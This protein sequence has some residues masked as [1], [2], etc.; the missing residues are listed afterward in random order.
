MLELKSLKF[1]YNSLPFI[2]DIS[3]RLKPGEILGL[4]GPNGSGK[5][6]ILKCLNRILKPREGEIFLDN[7]NINRLSLRETAAILGYVPQSTHSSFALNVFEMVLLGR[8]P[9]VNWKVSEKDRDIAFGMLRTMGLENMSF[10]IF[11]ELSGGEKQ[12]VLLARALCQEPRVLLLDEPTSNLDLKHQF[13]ILKLVRTL[14][15][16][17]SISVIMAVHDL[18]LALWFSNRILLLKDGIIYASGRTKEVLNEKNIKEVF[19]I[20]TI[21]EKNMEKDYIVP[22]IG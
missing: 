10:R 1:S 7:R 3:F 14:V 8:K 16:E 9:Y 11:N 20:E 17:R 13:E 4:L 2:R 22:V 19:G 21:I 12:K 6:T 18:N 15:R 5:T